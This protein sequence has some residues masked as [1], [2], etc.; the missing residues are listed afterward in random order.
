MNYIFAKL[1]VAWQYHG[2]LAYQYST[3]YNNISQ[4]TLESGA[5][6]PIFFKLYVLLTT[7]KLINGKII[8]VH[9]HN[10]F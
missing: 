5:N 9:I 10:K 6:R 3:I 4:Q 1:V 2:T 8:Y 7:N